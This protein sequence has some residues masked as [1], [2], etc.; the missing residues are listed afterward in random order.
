VNKW[1]GELR[2]YSPEELDQFLLEAKIAFTAKYPEFAKLLQS[3]ESDGR[4][5]LVKLKRIEEHAGTSAELCDPSPKFGN[6]FP[7]PHPAL[8]LIKG[9]ARSA[10][11]S[12]R[13]KMD[14]CG[15]ACNTAPVGSSVHFA[16][17]LDLLS[18]SWSVRNLLLIFTLLATLG[19]V[20]WIAIAR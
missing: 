15:S 6:A 8:S 11:R 18:N 7:D 10:T 2:P 17:S 9:G 4:P 20:C 19:L 5:Y 16:P 1:W 13:K 14:D 3:S 12:L